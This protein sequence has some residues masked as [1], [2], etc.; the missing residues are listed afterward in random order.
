MVLS[1]VG[2]DEHVVGYELVG[3]TCSGLWACSGLWTGSGLFMSM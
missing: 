3:W 2:D 1:T